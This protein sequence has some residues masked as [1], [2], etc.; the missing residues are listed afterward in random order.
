[1][2]INVFLVRLKLNTKG[3]KML[4]IT[5]C[6]DLNKFLELY[7]RTLVDFMVMVKGKVRAIKSPTFRPC[8]GF[9]IFRWR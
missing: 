3:F 1:M 6:G 2:M 8:D 5:I 4:S 9:N 7:T